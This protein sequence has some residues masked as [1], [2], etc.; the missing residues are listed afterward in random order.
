MTVKEQ[1]LISLPLPD[2]KLHA[3]NTGNW[4]A[5]APA[6]KALRNE[7]GLMCLMAQKGRKAKWNRA[8]VTYRFF[9]KDNRK[10]DSSNCVQSMKAAIDG[11]VDSGLIPDDCWQVLTVAGVECG[12]DRDNPRT[13]LVFDRVE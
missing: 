1:V 4:R 10:R 6:I 11:V 3:H 9:F 8:T 5:K 2:P 13:E 7:A 12:I